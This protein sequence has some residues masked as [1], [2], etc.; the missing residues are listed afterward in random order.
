[1]KISAISALLSDTKEIFYISNNQSKLRVDLGF[2][3][4]G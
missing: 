3:D 2:V 1:V 4:K